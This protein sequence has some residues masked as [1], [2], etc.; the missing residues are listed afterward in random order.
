MSDRDADDR[1]KS[2][3]ISI[4]SERTLDNLSALGSPEQSPKN[5]ADMDRNLGP[6]YRPGGSR[7]PHHPGAHENDSR[8]CG[9]D[10][11]EG[12][13]PGRSYHREG[14]QIVHRV[15]VSPDGVDNNTSEFTFEFKDG[16]ASESSRRRQDMPRVLTGMVIAH[17]EK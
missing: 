12:R 16:T 11:D 3:K 14:Q 13:S 10:Y 7:P 2:S 4:A 17:T 8:E 1:Y 9:Q 6:D 15:Q 5:Q